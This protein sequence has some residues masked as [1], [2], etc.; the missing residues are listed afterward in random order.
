MT[1]ELLR[2]GTAT[3]TAARFSQELDFLG[4]TFH[5]RVTPQATSLR[6]EFLSKDGGRAL[7]LLADALL[8]PA[9]AE[10][11]VS[12]ALAQRIEATRAIKDQPWMASRYYFR[13]F[14]FGPGHPYAHPPTGDEV[15]LAR[16]RRADIAGYHARMYVGRN[17]V[18][19]AAG[20][21]DAA[22]MSGALARRFSEAPAGTAYQCQ[23][24]GAPP[25][26]PR[27]LLIDQP[28]AAQTYFAIGARGI[29][30]TDPDRVV[31][32]LVN[33][34]FGGRFTSLLNQELRVNA[35]LTYGAM[36]A[37][38]EDRLPGTIAMFSYTRTADT[39]KAI[40]LALAVAARFRDQGITAGQLASAKAYLKGTYPPDR[41]ETADDLA[42]LLGELE[43]F[44]LGRDEVDSLFARL[45]AVTL[46][47]ANAVVRKHFFGG[48]L[49]FAFIG[50]GARIRES[51]RKYAP[52]LTEAPLGAP[53]FASFSRRLSP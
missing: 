33:T 32:S 16:I 51:L 48:G 15:S 4:A 20:D 37:V 18:V 14:F 6:M 31:V 49:V 12:K 21:F 45:D 38:D 24:A 25:P 8:H 40:D 35:G 13:A 41:L 22:A 52:A 23:P 11:E 19:V 43:L 53:G 2:R 26:G 34:L 1:A 50:D 46:E 42:A 7:E 17:L 10:A 30:R 29:T 36:S 39:A 27:L 9:I 28:E 44:G 47:Q 3:R 5:T